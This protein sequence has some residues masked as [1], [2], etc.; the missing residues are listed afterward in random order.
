MKNDNFEIIKYYDAPLQQVD[1]YDM[2]GRLLYSEV[3]G[4][5]LPITP[6]FLRKTP[7]VS[8]FKSMGKEEYNNIYGKLY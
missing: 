4:V 2:D 1:C 6:E 8:F 7:S 3:N 5:R